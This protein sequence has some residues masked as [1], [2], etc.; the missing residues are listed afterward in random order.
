MSKSP[1]EHGA[2]VL[3]PTHWVILEFITMVEL[4]SGQL[5]LGPL[6]LWQKRM[7]L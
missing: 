4:T 1:K 7:K 3:V 6:A 2:K 5:N